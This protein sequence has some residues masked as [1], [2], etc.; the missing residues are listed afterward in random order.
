[1]NGP[2]D[3]PERPGAAIAGTIAASGL[4]PAAVPSS[5]R[6]GRWST[7]SVMCWHRMFFFMT[8]GASA[9]AGTASSRHLAIPDPSVRGPPGQPQRS[10][11]RQ[12]IGKDCG[13]GG[14]RGYDAGKKV[15][16]RSHSGRYPGAVVVAVHPA[17]IQDRDRQAG[18]E[19]PGGAISPVKG[20]LGRRC[21]GG[22]LAWAWS[23]ELVRRPPQQRS[24]L[25]SGAH[26]RLAEPAT[27]FL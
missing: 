19:G 18:V 3:R 20:H 4:N 25:D 17:N 16:G 1:M 8:C 15:K 9:G 6:A 12:P 22:K 2:T 10:D 26:L 13:K 27:A 7:P 21:H 23:L 14:P 24:A 5:T 11:H